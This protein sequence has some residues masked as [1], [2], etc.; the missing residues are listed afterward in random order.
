MKKISNSL[1]YSLTLIAFVSLGS[2]KKEEVVAI[3]LPVINTLEVTYI[4]STTAVCGG[5][6]VSN[7]GSTIIQRGMNW[8]DNLDTLKNGVGNGNYENYFIATDTFNFSMAGLTPGKIY[9]VRAFVKNSLGIA[10]SNIITFSTKNIPINNSIFNPNLT[11][12]TV[13]D[14]DGNNYKTIIIGTQ[15][16]MAENYRVKHYLDGNSISGYKVNKFDSTNV[17]SYGL[18]YNFQS[19]SS[20]KFA[21]VG[22]HVPSADDWNNLIKYLTENGY[23]YDLSLSGNKVAKSLA[24]TTEWAFDPSIGNVGNN[25]ST[26][27]TSGFS[28]LPCG[29]NVSLTSFGYNA[30]WLTN[31]TRFLF[32]MSS[33]S[34]ELYQMVESSE[35]YFYTVRCIKD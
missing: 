27:N 12:G 19:V 28:A 17:K 14:I 34:E 23:N 16:W 32:I 3:Q 11:Y 2:C 4:T 6:I 24:A 5:K 30:V 21:P 25:I 29:I 7:G 31:D 15:T 26:N 18:F 20:S 8:S 10:Y 33:A 1:F 35:N 22:W 13:T 9:Y